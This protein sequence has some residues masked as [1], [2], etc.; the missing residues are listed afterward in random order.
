[1]F[2]K[3]RRKLSWLRIMIKLNKTTTTNTATNKQTG[4][5]H[6]LRDRLNLDVLAQNYRKKAQQKYVLQCIYFI[7]Y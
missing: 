2:G 3:F 6:T 5:I 7:V 4:N 1:M